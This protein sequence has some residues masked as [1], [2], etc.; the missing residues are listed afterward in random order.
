MLI[1]REYWY[2]QADMTIDGLGRVNE[3]V[4]NA[5]QRKK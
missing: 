2:S 3:R 4:V 5:I 1:E